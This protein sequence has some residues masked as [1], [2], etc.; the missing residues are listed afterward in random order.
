MSS[1]ECIVAGASHIQAL[2]S[3][4]SVPD[5]S[6]GVIRTKHP[7]RRFFGAYGPMPRGPKYWNAVIRVCRNKYVAILWT[8]NQHLSRFLVNLDEPFDVVCSTSPELPIDETVQL[9][10]EE[11][12]RELF[13]QGFDELR[14]VVR[15]IKRS[16]AIPLIC[17]TPP[18][19]GDD[20]FLR[21]VIFREQKFQRIA[22][23]NGMTQ[24]TIPLSSPLLRYKLW[25]IL[26]ETYADVARSEGVQFIP[27]P[28][29]AQTPEGYL[30]LKYAQQDA[31]HANSDYGL[32]MLEDITTHCLGKGDVVQL[33]TEASHASL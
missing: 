6:I 22:E 28:S 29:S 9:V 16:S 27:A 3:P 19:K 32:L 24:E 13:T 14:E 10:P 8:G 18:P 1:F 31:T 12:F 15:G 5:G 21:S 7:S 2:G 25:L 23:A 30:D 20:N 26:Q 17:G 11:V 4:V 33:I